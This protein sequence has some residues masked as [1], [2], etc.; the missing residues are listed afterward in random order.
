MHYHLKE[1][2]V[3]PPKNA[4]ELFNLRHASLRNAIA[5]AFG[6][7]KNRFPIIASTIEPSYCVDT[8]NE[9][10]FSCCILHNY[11]MGIDPDECLIVEVDKE[12]L[13]FHCERAAPSPRKDD[14][15]ARQ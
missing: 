1:Y 8:K 9:F 7:L 11:L 13:Y 14:E 10:I 5:R 15:H 2:S 3:R 4:K 6:I 12:V